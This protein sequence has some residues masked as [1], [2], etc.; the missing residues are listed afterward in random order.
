MAITRVCELAVMT[1]NSSSM[2]FTKAPGDVDMGTWTL[3]EIQ[4]YGLSQHWS[5]AR[6]RRQQA[7]T[8]SERLSGDEIRADGNYGLQILFVEDL[9]FLFQELEA[10]SS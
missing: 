1:G 6:E 9:G 4:R 5:G 3:Q 7:V 2:A 8:D 10:P